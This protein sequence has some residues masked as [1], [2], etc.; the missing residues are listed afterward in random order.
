VKTLNL[1]QL[2]LFSRCG[3][4]EIAFISC[5]VHCGWGFIADAFDVDHE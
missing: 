3:L 1:I 2:K 4:G 5:I